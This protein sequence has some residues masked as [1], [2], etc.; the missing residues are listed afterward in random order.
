[1]E[2][3][4]AIFKELYTSFLLRDFVG[5]IVPGSILLLAFGSLFTPVPQVVKS[6][7]DRTTTHF[8]ALVAGLAWT[9]VLGLQNTATS[10]KL[11]R[12]YPETDE[13]GAPLSEMNAQIL[14][15]Q[16]LQ[17]ACQAE[18][19][20]Y[21]RFVVIK[22]ATGNLYISLL[23]SIPLI[24]VSFFMYEDIATIKSE[25]IG[26]NIK[27]VR[28][29]IVIAMAALI[30]VSLRGMNQEHIHKQYNFAA[31]TLKH[32]DKHFCND[33]GAPKKNTKDEP[34]VETKT[35]SVPKPQK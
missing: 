24:L 8:L 31:E 5:K 33:D 22:E 19:Q 1:M 25:T 28:T 12:Y 23:L 14:V 27:A 2:A 17:I 15:E 10:L 30:V 35:R 3:F 16:F 32:L 9:M 34:N 11:W 13:T 18:R 29:V 20:Q 4:A 21:E 26:S 6:A 7:T